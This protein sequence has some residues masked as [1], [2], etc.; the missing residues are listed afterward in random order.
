MGMAW[1]FGVLF[2]LE[3]LLFVAYITTIFIAGQGIAIFI[4]L[5]PLS[6]HVSY[7]YFHHYSDHDKGLMFPWFIDHCTIVQDNCSIDCEEIEYLWA[8]PSYCTCIYS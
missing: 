1:V 7:S 2:F 4:L 8:S 3:E 5:L 6:K